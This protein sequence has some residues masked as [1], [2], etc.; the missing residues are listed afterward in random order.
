[1]KK[2]KHSE[3]IKAWADGEEIQIFDFGKWMDCTPEWSE[4]SRYRIKPLPKPDRA[5][6]VRV[7]ECP[8]NQRGV[9]FPL[10]EENLRLIFDGE[11]G[12]LKKAE[13]I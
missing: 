5:F 11:T 2:H 3:L 1:M 4:T 6:T 9:Y 10:K 8:Q 7:E 12:E 13:I